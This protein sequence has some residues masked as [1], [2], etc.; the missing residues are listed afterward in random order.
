MV[1]GRPPAAQQ[2]KLTMSII[3]VRHGETALN[4]ARV[5]QPADTPLSSRGRLQAAA[6]AQAMR[7]MRPAAILSSD[8]P[9]A[10]QTAEAIGHAT[11]LTTAISM[12]QRE[13]NF[14]NWRGLAYD[15]LGI[16]PLTLAEA[17]PGGESA[18]EFA[19]R[20][21]HAFAEAV[22]RRAGLAG[23]LVV[24]THGLV[25]RSVLAGPGGVPAAAMEA[26][27]VANTSV[28]VLAADPP[29]RVELLNSTHHLGGGA[30]DDPRGLVGG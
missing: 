21:M 26:L 11:G 1:T 20:A 3:L 12:L 22:G 5:L 18:A 28:S 10:L 29:H 19:Q 17:P 4:V 6:V 27:H 24:V 16:D 7:A 8:L 9:R 13:R 23:P 30:R 2:R 15:G 14:G 25:I